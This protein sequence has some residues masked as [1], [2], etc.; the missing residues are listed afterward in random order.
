MANTS[1][2][3]VLVASTVNPT[4][5]DIRAPLA[6]PNPAHLPTSIRSQQ[7]GMIPF[8]LKMAYL[9]FLDFKHMGLPIPANASNRIDLFIF[10][11]NNMR[12]SDPPEEWRFALK[13]LC[14]AF[15]LKTP[16]KIMQKL[17]YVVQLLTRSLETL[18]NRDEFIPDT[19]LTLVNKNAVKYRQTSRTVSSTIGVGAD[20]LMPLISWAIIQSNSPKIEQAVWLCSEYRHHCLQ[21]GECAYVLTQVSSA[22]EFCKESLYNSFDI[23]EEDFNRNL[24]LFEITQD[25]IAYCRKGSV[26]NVKISIENGADVN[27]LTPEQD[28]RPL[29][30]AVRS[31]N[32]EV[33]KI[34]LENNDLD[35]NAR[36][37]PYHCEGS[38]LD[39]NTP[40]NLQDCTPLMI[41]SMAGLKS[42]VDVLLS[43]G[44]DRYLFNE[45]EET[46]ASLAFVAGHYTIAQMLLAD[47]EFMSL[48]KAVQ[49]NNL[50][51]VEGLLL[52]SVTDVNTV[53]D[54][55]YE[56]NTPIFD[57][58]TNANMNI[59]NALVDHRNIDLQARNADSDSVLIWLCKA[60]NPLLNDNLRAEIACILLKHKAPRD[61]L[62]RFQKGALDCIPICSQ[63]MDEST[64]DDTVVWEYFKQLRFPHLA[65]VLYFDPTVHMVYNLAR[66]RKRDG[67]MSLLQQGCDPN[68]HCPTSLYTA[69][70]A[71]SFNNDIALIKVLLNCPTI[72]VNK[73]GQNQMTALHYACENS[74]IDV[75]ALLL[76]NGASRD[77]RNSYGETPLDCAVRNGH[78]SAADCIRFDPAKIS[79]CLAAKHGDLRVIEALV[80]QGVS[81]N[82]RKRHI[83]DGKDE[84]NH[85]LA[86]P[87][88]AAVSFGQKVLIK[89]LLSSTTF[90][91]DVDMT[92]ELGKSALVYAT[93]SGE[94]DI[95]L[96]LLKKGCNRYLRDNEGM[97]AADW[98]AKKGFSSICNI[99]RCDS[100]VS[101]VH[102]A[103]ILGD[104]DATIAFFKQDPNPNERWHSRSAMY[105]H[106]MTLPVLGDV[107]LQPCEGDT[108]LVVAA[109]YNQLPLIQLLLRAP[110]IDINLSDCIGKTPLMHAAQ[111]G[112]EAV[113]LL[114]LRSKAN[115]YC[116][117]YAGGKAVDYALKEGRTD[118]AFILKADPYCVFIQDCA[119]TGDVSLVD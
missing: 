4:E 71:A 76:Q 23:N 109:K 10:A 81:I 53:M 90:V 24:R 29:S 9:R 31:Q 62:D 116:L 80:L 18:L 104:I 21:M 74:F 113:A 83:I 22:L 65:S 101:S 43:F 41:A 28:D 107:A 95:V 100:S 69:L 37:C 85:Y 103:I 87:L 16:L 70:I 91:I 17:R 48:G 108:P 114:L 118:M 35:I 30:A 59:I 40:S 115:R 51:Y 66:E 47:P 119:D 82:N 7:R 52:Q 78:D 89:K 49:S 110:E 13:E 44:A 68:Q 15:E 6:F 86:T 60:T 92:D 63:S 12:K 55:G 27:G 79:I 67:V 88:I 36:I 19:D 94:E 64:V 112:F 93:L 98:A 56:G 105:S 61:A 11:H 75:I 20:E 73:S 57:A 46:A 77:I 3:C 50:F 38:R 99:L 2:I 32:M 96:Y 5:L 42:I 117:D 72:D 26:P 97:T 14:K 111:K 45:G 106:Q 39:E 8:R 1:T 54:T 84:I 33:L 25:L 102:N 34:L 58:I